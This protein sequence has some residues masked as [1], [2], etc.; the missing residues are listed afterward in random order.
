MVSCYSSSTQRWRQEDRKFKVNLG[1]TT[2]FKT[3]LVY[4][5]LCLKAETE[6]GQGQNSAS[7]RA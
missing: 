2:E 3:S 6:A 4:K 7:I 5:I 1:Y